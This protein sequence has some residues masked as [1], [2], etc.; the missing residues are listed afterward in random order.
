MI[1]LETLLPEE[2][3]RDL[4]PAERRVL[5]CTP[6]GRVADCRIGVA[7]Q[8]RPAGWSD[9]PSGE[10]LASGRAAA[11]RVDRSSLPLASHRRGVGAVVDFCGGRD[12]GS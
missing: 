2:L 3:Q 4:T 6:F 1:D 9:C 12:G 7:A 11:V 5:A 8:D 10:L